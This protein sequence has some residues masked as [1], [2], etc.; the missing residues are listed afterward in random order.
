M[1]TVQLSI[2]NSEYARSLRDSLLGDGTHRVYL[3]D[4]PDLRI[5]G[6]VVIDGNTL[7]KSLF[8]GGQPERFVVVTGKGTDSLSRLWNAG[9][10]H[11]VFEG[12]APGTAH[13]AVIA[14]EMRLPNSG[15]KASG[16]S[17]ASGEKHHTRHGPALP[18]LDPTPRCGRCSY[19][20]M[21]K[22]SFRGF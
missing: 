18:V 5:D 19:T 4:Q 1:K 6:I 10:R 9:I 15:P 12:D 7:D 14:A 2:R 3:V 13:L 21:H 17:G 8:L 20:S 16:L 22:Y 11:V